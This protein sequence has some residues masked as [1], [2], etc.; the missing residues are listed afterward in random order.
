[1]WMYIESA[2]GKVLEV[3][4]AKLTIENWKE[5]TK[6][7]L[8]KWNEEGKLENRKFGV[9][10]EFGGKRLIRE[11]HFIIEERTG[12]VLDIKGGT[13]ASGTEVIL[14]SKHGGSNQRWYIKHEDRHFFIASHI[15]KD[16]VLDVAG[17][18]KGGKL[19]GWPVTRNDNQ[20]WSM[21]KMGHM[22]CKMSLV[23]DISAE[24]KNPG[25]DVIGWNLHGGNNQLWT[26]EDGQ[27]KSN[28]NGLVMELNNKNEV[29]MSNPS[30]STRQTWTFVPNDL[31]LDFKFM[32]EN[33]NPLIEASFY[34]NVY[35]NYFWA[36]CGFTSIHALKRAADDSLKLMKNAAEQLDKVAVDTGIAGSVGGGSAI[37][38]SVMSIAGLLL[39]PFTGGA[40]LGLTFGGAAVG[41]AGGATSLT[42]TLINQAW[43]KSEAGKYREEFTEVRSGTLRLQSFLNIYIEKLKAAAV[44]LKTKEG[45]KLALDVLKVAD[46][47]TAAEITANTGKI[48]WN[49]YKFGTTAYKFGTTIVKTKDIAKTIKDA[50]SLVSFIQAD[51]YA[52]KGIK[53]GV[54]IAA[55]SGIKIPIIGKTLVMAGTKTAASLTVIFSVVGIAFGI[56]EVVDSANKIKN[57]SELAKEFR[58]TVEEVKGT[59]KRLVDLDQELQS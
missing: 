39:A 59:V 53:E 12:K 13:L 14:W 47:Y 27:L 49:A 3:K 28:L 24:N 17:S 41:I 5:G 35:D 19:L 9:N 58:K 26:F 31:L 6:S 42:G 33:K 15:N 56:W 23:A 4:Q 21:D 7:Q 54:A 44:F 32:E 11:N 45:E 40:S 38:G 50:K 22:I 57:G 51:Y 2:S 52:M 46:A 43:E 16:L 10:W 37:T 20:L 55:A 25:A 30:K 34:K 1:M 18:S 29:K 36:V 48:G 8:W